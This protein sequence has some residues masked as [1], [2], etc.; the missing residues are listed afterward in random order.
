[1]IK[2]FEALNKQLT[3]RAERGLNR[4]LIARKQ[5]AS[6]IQLANNDY[7]GLSQSPSVKAAA[8]SAIDQWGTSASASPLVTGYT[9][10][11]AQLER[12]LAELVGF[13]SALIWNTGYAANAAVLSLFAKKGD[14]VLADRLIHRSLLSGIIQS[15]AQLIR[16]PH[17][18]LE[19]LESIL[20]RHGS[21]HQNIFVVT[22]SVFS[23]D[24]DYPDLQ[25]IAHLKTKFSFI[26]ILDEAHAFG[27]YG[28]KG[29]GLAA[30][31]GVSNAVDIL[32]G[33]LGKALGSMGAFTLFQDKSLRHACIQLAPEFIY[34]TYLCPA[35]V[36][37]ALESIRIASE[38]DQTIL[39]SHSKAFRIKI[40]EV[41]QSI[42]LAPLI[43]LT[44]FDSPIIP[45]IIG[46]TEKILLI[47]K[48]LA[49]SGFNV[50]SIRPPTVPEGT[51]RLRLS[52]NMQFLQNHQ[53][54]FIAAFKEALS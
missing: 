7:L 54:S 46:D 1:M 19:M 26:W 52:L 6:P 36:G 17:L 12:T 32:I 10:L 47:A 5:N 43:P 25:R 11:H 42:G 18:D 29:N 22:E 38:I 21:K 35:A 48:R 24:G 9:E 31:A 33:T 30:H 37:A 53:D 44:R 27:W 8:K 16:Y 13:K 28:P 49:T 14:L 23:M 34:S 50:G 20:E 15:G 41:L 51:A 39:Q 2:R 3:E 45:I 40:T 4:S